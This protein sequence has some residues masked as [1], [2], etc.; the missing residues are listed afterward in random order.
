MFHKVPGKKRNG[1]KIAQS[2]LFGH[3]GAQLTR[4]P[5]VTG[6]QTVATASWW[7]KPTG[8]SVGSQT[9]YNNVFDCGNTGSNVIRMSFT[10]GSEPGL[11][12]NA[13]KSGAGNGYWNGTQNLS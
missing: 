9:S 6:S 8:V 13:Y 2:C 12:T 5:T 1:Y 11:Q 7:S 4:T 10:D 3:S